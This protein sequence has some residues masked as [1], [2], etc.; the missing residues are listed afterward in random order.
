V[1]FLLNFGHKVADENRYACV[2]IQ[3]NGKLRSIPI[4]EDAGITKCQLVDSHPKQKL[5]RQTAVCAKGL[6]NTLLVWC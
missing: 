5:N 3:T 1:V 6:N 2:T 4:N